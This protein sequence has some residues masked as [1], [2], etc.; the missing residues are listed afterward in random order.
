MAYLTA[1]VKTV[2]ITHVDRNLR[3]IITIFEKDLG[4][5]CFL[6]FGFFLHNTVKIIELFCE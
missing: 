2:V 4:F 5:F 3:V 1:V 6:F